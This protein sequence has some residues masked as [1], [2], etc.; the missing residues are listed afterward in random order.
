MDPEYAEHQRYY[1]NDTYRLRVCCLA[2]RDT[3][4][5]TQEPLSRQ[6]H[7]TSTRA[8]SPP[9]CSSNTLSSSMNEMQLRS[10]TRCSARTSLVVF[11]SLA[12]QGSS[13]SAAQAS[14]LRS[15]LFKPAAWPVS[16]ADAAVQSHRESS[17][18][19]YS[20]S[21]SSADSGPPDYREQP[22]PP[23]CS[24]SMESQSIP[25]LS[26]GTCASGCDP[27]GRLTSPPERRLRDGKRSC[28]PAWSA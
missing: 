19:N 8:V 11:R 7:R 23:N 3:V 12:P 14:T 21:C 10:S 13:G 27:P 1:F 9:T 5:A 15:A 17:H 25:G 4:S 24:R 22:S 28:S 6:G 2:W 18:E 16:S 26:N 20:D